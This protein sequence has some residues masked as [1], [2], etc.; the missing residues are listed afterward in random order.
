VE[1][2]LDLCQLANHNVDNPIHLESV[3]LLQMQVYFHDHE[4][5]KKINELV[6]LHLRVLLHPLGQRQ[7]DFLVLHYHQ[8]PF[9]SPL[10]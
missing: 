3:H 9:I 10:T 4:R 8:L 7:R 1:D 5:N 6:V 2:Y